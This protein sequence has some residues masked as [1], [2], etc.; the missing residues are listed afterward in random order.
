MRKRC[1][2]CKWAYLPDGGWNRP[3][4]CAFPEKESRWSYL[5]DLCKHF[6]AERLG[7]S[8]WMCDYQEALRGLRK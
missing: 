6:Q 7:D 5:F 2:M 4:Q 3:L 1:Y 8:E